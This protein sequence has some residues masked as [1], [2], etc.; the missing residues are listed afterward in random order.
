MTGMIHAADLRACIQKRF[1]FCR[2]KPVMRLGAV[3]LL[4]LEII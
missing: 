4:F 3:T 1:I 2:F